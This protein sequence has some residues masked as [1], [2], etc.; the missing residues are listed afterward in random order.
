ML[1][2]YNLIYVRN[3]PVCDTFDAFYS[4]AQREMGK[5][6][7]LLKNFAMDMETL[8]H[9]PIHPAISEKKNLFLA[10][11]VPLDKLQSWAMNCREA[12][13]MFLIEC[14]SPLLTSKKTLWWKTSWKSQRISSLSRLEPKRKKMS[15]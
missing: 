11:L 9:I 15:I 12:H 2:L 5:H 4:Q 10:D 14:E 6:A 13:G 8:H 1:C 7:T 3:S